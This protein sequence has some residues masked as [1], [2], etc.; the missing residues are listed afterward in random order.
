MPRIVKLATPEVLAL[1][2]V[3]AGTARDRSVTVRMPCWSRDFWVEAETDSGTRATVSACLVAVTTMSPSM[4][5]SP[6]PLAGAA[7]CCARAGS[8]APA[9]V[10]AV[11]KSRAARRARCCISLS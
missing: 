8:A 1:V 3:R 2:T 7:A 10:R 9:E 11:V 6:A 5:E 4:A